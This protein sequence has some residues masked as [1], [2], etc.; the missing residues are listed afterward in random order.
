MEGLPELDVPA[1]LQDMGNPL[2][3][4]DDVIVLTEL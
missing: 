2:E 4:M 3:D 1:D